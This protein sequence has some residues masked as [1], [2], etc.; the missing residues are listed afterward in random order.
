MDRWLE[1]LLKQCTVYSKSVYCYVV[2]LCRLSQVAVAGYEDKLNICWLAVRISPTAGLTED[3]LTITEDSS[4]VVNHI[5]GSK[6][7]KLGDKIKVI[8]M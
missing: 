3:I 5:E 8:C 7:K 6:Q 1:F 4:V 2:Y